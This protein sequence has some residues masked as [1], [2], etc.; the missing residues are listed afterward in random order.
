MPKK[1]TT[2]P[3][4]AKPAEGSRRTKAQKADAELYSLPKTSIKEFIEKE[5]RH[6]ELGRLREI[7]EQKN[8]WRNTMLLCALLNLGFLILAYIGA[9]NG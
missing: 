8:V 9:F 2:A 5:R 3:P 6:D 7:Q 1:V 4:C